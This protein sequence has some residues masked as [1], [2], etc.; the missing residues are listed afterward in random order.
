MR[1]PEEFEYDGLGKGL[2]FAAVRALKQLL[3]RDLP[4]TIQAAGTVP[5][6]ALEGFGRNSDE[7]LDSFLQQSG[8]QPETAQSG[9]G[10]PQEEG[11]SSYEQL[12]NDVG[13]IRIGVGNRDLKRRQV[14]L[15]QGS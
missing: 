11:R 15:R 8:H 5:K 12:P 2:R 3:G 6:I 4:E 10:N 9:V 14:L 13:G 7:Q 1:A